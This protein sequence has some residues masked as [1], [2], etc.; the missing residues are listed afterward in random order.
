[1][2]TVSGALQSPLDVSDN[3]ETALESKQGL[4][5]GNVVCVHYVLSRSLYGA[6]RNMY[7]SVLNICAVNILV[8]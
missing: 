7:C 8:L 1:M 6:Q 3:L 5:C 4:S 2:Q